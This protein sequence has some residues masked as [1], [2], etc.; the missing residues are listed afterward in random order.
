MDTTEATHIA[1]ALK[2]DIAKKFQTQAVDRFGDE[3]ADYERHRKA[4]GAAFRSL[5]SD[6][7]S[8]NLFFS[9]L[10]HFCFLIQTNILI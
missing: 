7:E 8:R 4:L 5:V 10:S 2:A 1:E 9:F 6:F 3:G